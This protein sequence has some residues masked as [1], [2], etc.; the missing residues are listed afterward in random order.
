MHP[1]VVHDDA[2]LFMFHE[3]DLLVIL[4]KKKGMPFFHVHEYALLVLF[5]GNP[6][7][8]SPL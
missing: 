8:G 5:L 4:K 1:L 2:L 6:Q 3:Y 7:L